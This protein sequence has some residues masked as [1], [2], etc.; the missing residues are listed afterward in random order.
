[1]S[2]TGLDY[3]RHNVQCLKDLGSDRDSGRMDVIVG[4]KR[5]DAKEHVVFFGGDVQVC[6]MRDIDFMCLCQCVLVC[7]CV[8]VSMH[9]C[10]CVCV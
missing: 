5:H 9:V 10:V 1:M 2:Q 4:G 7:A 8:C 3:S 6:E